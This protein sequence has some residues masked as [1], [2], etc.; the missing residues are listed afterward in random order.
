MY[1]L[2]TFLILLALL[3]GGPAASSTEGPFPDA[4]AVDHPK[5]LVGRGLPCERVPLGEA[6]DYK[7][8]IALLPSSELL[9]T[10]FH[11]Y[12]RP[13]NKVLEQTLLF[14]SKD[15]GRTWSN[16]EKLDLLGREPYLTVLTDGTIIITGHLLAGDVR[17][18]WGYTCGFLHRSTD[19][20]K[21][22][23]SI[24]IESEGTKPNASNHTT[25]NVLQL[26][27]GTL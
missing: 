11:Q 7:P 16:P 8:C 27:D 22:W 24:R 4:V 6:D 23:E 13:G 1:L 15:G 25:R 5:L 9:L 2:R 17:N 19:G 10:A 26:A 20:G 21:T 12:Q 3:A 14:R 18:R